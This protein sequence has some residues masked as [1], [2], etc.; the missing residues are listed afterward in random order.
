VSAI[1]G[2]VGLSLPLS[3]KV[4]AEVSR[5]TPAYATRRG[6]VLKA[7]QA[8]S[9][10]WEKRFGSQRVK[11]LRDPLL[12]G[13][14][15]N[16]TVRLHQQVLWVDVPEAGGKRDTLGYVGVTDV[17]GD[18]TLLMLIGSAAN[19][20]D[21]HPE[22]PTRSNSRS[23][24]AAL[25]ALV[26][27][28]LVEHPDRVPTDVSTRVA[29]RQWS[30]RGYE[31]TRWERLQQRLGAPQYDRHAVRAA[32]QRDLSDVL[33]RI[34]NEADFYP[35]RPRVNVEYEVI[36]QERNLPVP[37]S[38]AQGR[39]RVQEFDRVILAAPL[40]IRL[41]APR[42]ATKTGADRAGRGQ[43]WTKGMKRFDELLSSADP[44]SYAHL[45]D[46]A[47]APH[48]LSRAK[49]AQAKTPPDLA[50]DNRRDWGAFLQ[51]FAEQAKDANVLTTTWLQPDPHF[52]GPPWDRRVD[53][54]SWSRDPR[55]TLGPQG[56]VVEVADFTGP[57]PERLP[58]SQEIA[59]R[60]A[61][62]SVDGRAWPS[63]PTG[64]CLVDTY[65]GRP[66]EWPPSG[67]AD[68][69]LAL[70]RAMAARAAQWI[71]MM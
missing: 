4:S 27:R 29:L 6:A 52:G 46:S 35:D 47:R 65:T 40:V 56:W 57:E 54:D 28:L 60:F 14:L 11:N 62:I 53:W 38:D 8:T 25:D 69:D 48:R 67:I 39:D 31:A 20:W 2:E 37:V 19:S 17:D 26:R 50:L 63:D 61:F 9:D 30:S 16:T 55:M 33:F 34:I 41:E 21:E 13:D 23:S 15:V 32:S 49:A 22:S 18:L 64:A 59:F 68:P 42:D 24:E 58:T 71:S 70:A 3:G 45:R 12:S 1:L 51:W 10:R 7:Y 36:L 43:L 5:T 66:I 44:Q